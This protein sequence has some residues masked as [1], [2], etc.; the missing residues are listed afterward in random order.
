MKLKYSLLAVLTTFLLLF[1]GCIY[2]N[3]NMKKP[4]TASL[5]LTVQVKKSAGENAVTALTKE[6]YVKF[7]YFVPSTSGSKSIIATK[8]ADDSTDLDDIK[9]DFN[10]GNTGEKITNKIDADLADDAM[11]D[12]VISEV[13]LNA[14]WLA[15]GIPGKGYDVQLIDLSKKGTMK[16]DTEL[17]L[18]TI[19]L[20]PRPDKTFTVKAVPEMFGK[21][22]LS[23][24]IYISGPFNGWHG[25]ENSSPVMVKGADGIY[26]YTFTGIAPG[27]FEYKFNP[28]E[29]SSPWSAD[30][31]GDKLVDDGNGGSNPKAIVN[32]KA[33][34]KYM[35]VIALD[36]K[37]FSKNTTA[38]AIE[39]TVDISK[40][41]KDP[42]SDK[43][44]KSVKINYA[45]KM[46]S[47]KII[48]GTE[49]STLSN[50]AMTLEDG[51]Y[52]VK[53]IK[54]PEVGEYLFT[55]TAVDEYGITAMSSVYITVMDS[56]PVVKSVTVKHKNLETVL[57]QK[58]DWSYETTVT[59][60]GAYELGFMV[61]GNWQN[62][63]ASDAVQVETKKD[64][65]YT[66]TISAPGTYELG[67]MVDGNWQNAVATN[68]VSGTGVTF[69]PASGGNA[70]FTTTTTD[71]AITINYAGPAKVVTVKGGFNGWAEVAL[72]SS[73]FVDFTYEKSTSGNAKFTT[74]V[75][76]TA[77]KIVFNNSDYN[78]IPYGVKVKGSFNSW[79]EV[80][81]TGG[82]TVSVAP[83]SNKRMVVLL[84]A[85]VEDNDGMKDIESVKADLTQFDKGM[86][87]LLNDGQ[88]TVS[89]DESS[90]DKVYTNSIEM[91]LLIGTYMIPV[92]VKDKSGQET[93]YN[94]ELKVE[95]D[96]DYSDDENSSTIIKDM[97]SLSNSVKIVFDA[98]KMSEMSGVDL[99]K[100]NKVIIKGSIIDG[101]WAKHI[102]LTKDDTG[103]TWSGFIPIDSKTGEFGF[104]YWTSDGTAN[105]K[106]AGKNPD[107]GNNYTYSEGVAKGLIVE[108]KKTVKVVFDATK[109]SEMDGVDLTKIDKM[110]IKGSII[111]S[112]WARQIRLT[113]SNDDNTWYCYTEIASKTGEFG[114][115]YWTSDGTANDKWAGKNPDT[116]NNYTYSEGME[117]G[118]IVEF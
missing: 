11:D 112:G 111:D 6:D 115:T 40:Y 65:S 64:W 117:K 33:K 52:K 107:T 24:P 3:N 101:S 92:I 17:D 7:W 27:E 2:E 5:K 22:E 55:I 84:A 61:D 103:D 49:F 10:E 51:K 57:K 4:D 44:I 63:T 9:N 71:T 104:A 82:K 80:A 89:G 50:K 72:S 81:L 14:K 35:P 31:T 116:G 114:F 47:G 85:K 32:G 62:A 113:K 23:K 12:Y 118:L 43:T 26:T 42:V 95:E 110:I 106:W 79:A 29:F 74:T 88:A 87:T 86:L 45:G 18:G 94:A 53:N 93:T 30:P 96:N 41:I 68:S 78:L 1:S 56:A 59:T 66:T 108:G 100:I 91:N 73:T 98:T 37:S 83:G 90:T 13:P 60:P 77:I 8:L 102:E 97:G 75:T 19:I 67:F 15:V 28:S 70:K 46:V 39:V 58:D 25:N 105:D 109:L 16:K 34:S 69:E 54:I 21:A 20:Q 76:N 38:D 99:S 48:K 36:T